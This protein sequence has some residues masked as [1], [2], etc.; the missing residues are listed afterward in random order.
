MD[1]S[2]GTA[3]LLWDNRYR[4]DKN[5]SVKLSKIIV[6]KTDLIN[7][8]VVEINTLIIKAEKLNTVVIEI[9]KTTKITVI[10]IIKII[11]LE[12][13]NTIRKISGGVLALFRNSSISAPRKCYAFTRSRA[14]V[15]C[16]QSRKNSHLHANAPQREA[17]IATSWLFHRGS[18]RFPISKKIPGR[19]RALSG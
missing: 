16:P 9:D 1:G 6:L 18:R 12:V 15:K 8:M 19:V 11:R 17:F 4:T 13:K 10:E 3:L 14:F 2:S 7:R 5:S